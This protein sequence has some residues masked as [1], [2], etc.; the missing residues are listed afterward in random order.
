M[1]I[2]DSST[3]TVQKQTLHYDCGEEFWGN[4]TVLMDDGTR[5]LCNCWQTKKLN[6]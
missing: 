3:G 1:F 5:L 2:P 4:L 6:L